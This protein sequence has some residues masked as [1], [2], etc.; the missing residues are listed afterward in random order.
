MGDLVSKS[1]PLKNFTE[2]RIE[3][4]VLRHLEHYHVM[5]EKDR[6]PAIIRE[7]QSQKSDTTLRNQIPHSLQPHTQLYLT[8]R[9]RPELNFA[10]VPEPLVKSGTGTRTGTRLCHRDRD[11]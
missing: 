11:R 7:S 6:P 10:P 9:T 5:I 3:G 8:I 4:Q 1:K 2:V